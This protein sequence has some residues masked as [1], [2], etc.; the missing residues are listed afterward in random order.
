MNDADETRL[1]LQTLLTALGRAD[2]DVILDADIPPSIKPELRRIIGPAFDEAATLIKNNEARLLRM[3]E[4]V[5]LVSA[6][7]QADS[8]PPFML[9]ALDIAARS[10]E[11]GQTLEKIADGDFLRSLAEP[12]TPSGSSSSPF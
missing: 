9:W 11:S 12:S 5:I 6:Q 1:Q 7:R 10:V 4:R 3:F 2:A 8:P